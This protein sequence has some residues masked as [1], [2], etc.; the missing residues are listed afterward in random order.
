MMLKPLQEVSLVRKM[1]NGL[2]ESCYLGPSPALI[3]GALI[4]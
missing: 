4:V 2:T 3:A 1:L